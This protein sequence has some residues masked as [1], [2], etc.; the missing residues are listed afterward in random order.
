MLPSLH[1][2]VA[3]STQPSYPPSLTASFKPTP[4][5]GHHLDA[6][7]AL[8]HPLHPPSPTMHLQAHTVEPTSLSLHHLEATTSMLPPPSTSCCCLPQPPTATS[9]NHPLHTST[10]RHGPQPPATTTTTAHTLTIPP[11]VILPMCVPMLSPSCHLAHVHRIYLY[12]LCS[13]NK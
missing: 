2:L 12:V 5:Q 10:H 11:H 9:L 6:P 13:Y 7:S 1:H 8:M 3:T 4:S